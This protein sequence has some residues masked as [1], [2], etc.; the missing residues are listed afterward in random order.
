MAV[1]MRALDAVVETVRPDGKTRSIPIA[2]FH[3]LP[4]N[5]PH[6]ETVLERG[7]TDH[8]GDAAQAGRRHAHLSQGARPRVL[9]LRAG[10]GRRD[11]AARR[12]RPRCARRCRP[13][14]V[15][16]R[17]GRGRVAARREGRY[18]SDCSPA[19][20]R[21]A[22]THSSCRWS[23]ARSP[24]CSP[25]RGADV[26]KFD[27]PATTNP[28]DQLKVV[29]KPTDRIDG[30]LK[31]T[32]T[33]HLRLR[34]SRRRAERGLRLCCRRGDRQG[35]DRRDRL[36]RSQGRARRARDRH[37]GER[38][39]ARQGRVQH[40]QAARRPRDRALPSGDRAR[41]R[42]DLR[43]GARGRATR[44]TSTTSAPRARSILPRRRTRAIKPAPSYRWRADT[45]VG[46]FDGAF[47]AAPVQARRNLHHAR[48]VAR[49]DG[50]ARVDRRVGRRQAHA[51]DL[52][53]D[54]RLGH[55]RPGEDARHPQRER[56]PD[57]ALHRRR[58]RRQ[59][60]SCVPTRCSRRSARARPAGR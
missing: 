18:R 50:A 53:P 23:S 38:R 42:R 31:T 35:P 25:R 15:A 52:E 45:A 10:L 55:R 17:G 12:D 57:L 7:R 26:M 13:Q 54:D 51:L 4:G 39:Q 36:W 29:G 19:P 24:R 33:A 20:S 48:S 22:K 8:R 44:A 5:T 59:S 56:A 60:C 58:L 28:I 32:G 11:R 27:T 16:R 6:I 46:D 41:R 43:A 30:P 2:D 3:R 37:R 47:A 49:D 9:R 1:A 34:A 14:A 21:P 40:R